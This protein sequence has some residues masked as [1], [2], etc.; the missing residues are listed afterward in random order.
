[1]TLLAGTKTSRPLSFLGCVVTDRVCYIL[2]LKCVKHLRL[3]RG[4]RACFGIGL[5]PKSG[6][7][8]NVDGVCGRQD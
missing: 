3:H 2:I 4:A 5:G 7:N 8:V 1:M 6:E